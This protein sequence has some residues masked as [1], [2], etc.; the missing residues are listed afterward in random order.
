MTRVAYTKK[1]K[2]EGR[3]N[4]ATDPNS[5]NCAVLPAPHP[6]RLLTTARTSTRHHRIQPTATQRWQAGHRTHP[7]SSGRGTPSRPSEGMAC[8][9]LPVAR[10]T[11]NV[12]CGKIQDTALE[13]AGAAISPSKWCTCAR[14]HHSVLHPVP[15]LSLPCLECT[16]RTHVQLHVSPSLWLAVA[17]SHT[18]FENFPPSFVFLFFSLITVR[19]RPFPR[20]LRF[21]PKKKACATEALL[22]SRPCFPAFRALVCS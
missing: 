22:P 21:R 10:C 7:I 2:E 9:S 16:Q 20:A 4:S 18:S 14:T 1:K 17:A 3:R 5:S 12:S 15:P 8:P 11:D 13:T 19:R 6:P